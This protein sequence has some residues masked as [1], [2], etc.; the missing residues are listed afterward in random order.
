MP[1]QI[2]VAQADLIKMT[3]NVKDKTGY[4]RVHNGT[5]YQVAG[6]TDKNEIVLSNGW[7]MPEDFQNFTYGYTSTSHASQGRTTDKVIIGL[8]AESYPATSTEQ[9]YVSL[10]RGKQEALIVT[11][12]KEE[13]RQRAMRADVRISAVDLF[14]K[15]L[16]TKARMRSIAK[17]IDYQQ[18]VVPQFQPP[19]EHVY[20]R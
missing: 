3:A 6:F 1:E 8:S 16:K 10:S 12:S 13:L 9:M 17:K 7:T 5:V 15:R 18:Q 11:D 14:K 2:Q 4:H 20:E 19:K